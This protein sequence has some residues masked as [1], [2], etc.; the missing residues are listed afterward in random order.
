MIYTLLIPFTEGFVLA[1]ATLYIGYRMGRHERNRVNTK[2][3][4]DDFYMPFYNKEGKVG[5][6]EPIVPEDI[7]KDAT[8]IGDFIKKTQI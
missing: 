2:K 4:T 1:G 8:D 7:F 6:S 3:F 5:F